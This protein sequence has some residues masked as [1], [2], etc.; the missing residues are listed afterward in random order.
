MSGFDWRYDGPFVVA[1]ILS[2]ILI[3]IIYWFTRG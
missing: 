3:G 2:A 1:F